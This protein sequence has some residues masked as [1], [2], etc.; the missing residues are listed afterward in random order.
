[1]ALV[2]GRSEAK[3]LKIKRSEIHDNASSSIP[4]T[5]GWLPNLFRSIVSRT[6]TVAG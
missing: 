2:P 1:M 3:L 4:S 6:E 5:I